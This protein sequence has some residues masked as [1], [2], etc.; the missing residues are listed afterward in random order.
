MNTF[1]LRV[2]LI[3]LLNSFFLD[4]IS[5]HSAVHQLHQ[6]RFKIIMSKSEVK[7]EF[8]I[9]FCFLRDLLD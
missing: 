5:H 6:E 8:R 4:E 9:L 3:N 1:V 2:V 7:I